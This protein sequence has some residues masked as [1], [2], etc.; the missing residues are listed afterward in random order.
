MT[1]DTETAESETSP[2]GREKGMIRVEWDRSGRPTVAIVEAIAEA[3]EREPTALPSL[4]DSID[5]EALDAFLTR[6][7]HGEQQTQVSFTYDGASVSVGS[8][9]ILSIRTADPTD[10]HADE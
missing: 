10:E 5:V 6:A 1:Y 7:V 9:G 2:S 8:D 3:T 4:Y